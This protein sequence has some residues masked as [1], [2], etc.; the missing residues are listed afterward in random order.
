MKNNRA[1]FD[2][3]KDN[4]NR[5]YDYAGGGFYVR[6][7]FPIIDRWIPADSRVIDLGAGN[8]SLLK[9]LSERKKIKIEGLEI[10]PS[11]V[12]NCLKNNLTAR[13]GEI[14]RTGT[15]QNYADNEFDY[16]ICNVTLQM[17]MYPE[18]L[19]QEMAR[20]SK[21]LI[22]SF[23]NF[24]YLGNRLDLLLNGVMPRPMLHKYQWFN[25][26]HIH[27]LSNRDFKIFCRRHNLRIIKQEPLGCFKFI[28]RFVWRN[29]FSKESVFLCEKYDL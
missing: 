18:I 20:I 1:D 22:I 21:Y 5:R 24:A 17:V 14:D 10:S 13:G 9:Y 3:P 4:D 7:E 25:T 19:L 27:Q 23:P 12:A 6:E 29:L 28:A 16:A 11:G 2:N 26:G 15:Y 8:G